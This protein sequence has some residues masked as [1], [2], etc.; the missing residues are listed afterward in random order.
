[1]SDKHF[2]DECQMFKSMLPTPNKYPDSYR[3]V[4]KILKNMGM[5]YEVIHACEY[6]CFLFY[7]DDAGLDYC[8]VC[9][10]VKM[11]KF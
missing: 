10:G 7:K 4:K 5:G 9:K 6:S 3:E 11:S 1:M 2:N 8:P